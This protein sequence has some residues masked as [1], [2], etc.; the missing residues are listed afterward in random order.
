MIV[1]VCNDVRECDI[2]KMVEQ[3]ARTVRDVQSKCLAGTS[4]GSCI[5]AIKA[6]LN[7]QKEKVPQKHSHEDESIVM[8]EKTA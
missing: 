3:G 7:R 8:K 5:F 2:K 4:C 6:C 1:C